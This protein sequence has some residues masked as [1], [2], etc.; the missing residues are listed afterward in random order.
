MGRGGTGDG[1]AVGCGG[2]WGGDVVRGRRVEG[3]R[4][5]VG[6][7]GGAADAAKRTLR[8]GVE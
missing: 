5:A 6:G 2:R 3:G 4:K 1:L 8:R 7:W